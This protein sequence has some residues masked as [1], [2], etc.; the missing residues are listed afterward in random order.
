MLD[1][2]IFRRAWKPVDSAIAVSRD[3]VSA[4]AI[5]ATIPTNLFIS[6][7]LHLLIAES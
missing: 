4:D 5:P 6:V 2:L 3:R 1:E 7:L